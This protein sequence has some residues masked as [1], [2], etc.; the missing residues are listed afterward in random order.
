MEKIA[1][2]TGRWILTATIL[3]SSMAF[4]DGSAL[5]IVLSDIQ[6]GLNA[7]GAEM[8]WIV[9]GYLLFLAS[10]IL[11]G[12]S[13]GDHLGRKRIFMI[14]IVLFTIASFLCGISPNTELMIVARM[15]QG[16]GGAL[17]V[18]GSLA[19]ISAS[20]PP[21]ERGKAIGTWSAFSSV[22]TVLG[23]VLGG[24]MAEVDFWRGIFFINIPLAVVTLWILANY[25]PESRDEQA[26]KLDLPGALLVTLGLAGLSYGFIEAPGQG[27][28]NPGIIASLIVGFAALILF[29]MVESRSQHPMVPLKLFE[30][31]T[32]SGTNIMTFFLY[33]ALAV[34]TLFLPLNFA[35]VQDYR[36]IEISLALLPFVLSLTLLSRWAGTLV[37]RYGPRLPLTVGP[38]IV[39]TGFFA[40]TLPGLTNGFAEFWTTYFP[41]ILIMGIGMGITVAPLTTAVMG[42]VS[43]RQAGVASGVNNAVAR[44]AGVLAIAI[45]GALALFSFR[46]ALEDRTESIQLSQEERDTLKKNASDLGN[47]RPPESLDE[48]AQSAIKSAVRSAFV[49]TFRLVLIL[50]A[51]LAWLSAALA[52][53][54]VDQRLVVLE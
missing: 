43:S 38:A 19:I 18:P 16:V 46:S 15:V 21:G 8:L 44:T 26:K 48:T 39:G 1:P 40:V 17:M 14:G 35:Q 3:A 24:A 22:T 42:S 52:W 31:P 37:D 28:D 5:N 50:T 20:F 4:I 29:V 47:T 32:F 10:L 33:G 41:G 27:F 49:E 6:D 2:Q 30:S 25:V 54:T 36:R 12:G 11:V 53:L 13:L 9:D 51:I 7:S 45:L 34:A 23:P